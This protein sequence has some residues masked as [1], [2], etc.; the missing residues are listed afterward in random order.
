MR[1]SC[2]EYGSSAVSLWEAVEE[3][4]ARRGWKTEEG[5]DEEG[6]GYLF[7]QAGTVE[8]K[9]FGHMLWSAIIVSG[10]EKAVG[11]LLRQFPM[12]IEWWGESGGLQLDGVPTLQ[13][14]RIAARIAGAVC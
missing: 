4:A 10:E 11:E 7:V 9:V 13:T 14:A 3:V 5:V 2:S 6:V 12:D 8:V 1:I